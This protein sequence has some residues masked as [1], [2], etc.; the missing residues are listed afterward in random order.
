[1][2]FISSPLSLLESI[3]SRIL[4][5]S[6]LALAL[7]SYI[8]LRARL[9]FDML[10]PRT[11]PPMARPSRTIGKRRSI[12]NMTPPVPLWDMA[13]TSTPPIPARERERVGL[14]HLVGT[15]A[16]ANIIARE[17]PT[18]PSTPILRFSYKSPFIPSTIIRC[19]LPS[20]SIRRDVSPT[21]R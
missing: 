18:Y 19:D 11:S 17:T 7:F 1:M 12:Q 2:P 4:C 6:T 9:A 20:T 13:S 10:T 14:F 15:L 5:S 8:Y 16:S 21:S 3:H